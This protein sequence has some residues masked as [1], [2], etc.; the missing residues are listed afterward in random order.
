M[1]SEILDVGI[2]ASFFAGVIAFLSPCILPLM[3]GYLSVVTH[4]SHEDLSDARNLPKFS[5]VVV[6]SLVFILGFSTVFISLGAFSSQLGG[7]I[8]GN[9]TFLLRIA[10]IF[11]ILFGIFVMEIVKI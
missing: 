2:V 7:M 4:L 6:P 10:G 3:P 11:I 5:R 9:K 1:N 8:S